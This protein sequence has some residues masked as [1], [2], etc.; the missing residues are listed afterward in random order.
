MHW[1]QSGQKNLYFVQDILHYPKLPS[2][3]HSGEKSSPFACLFF[4]FF[5]V[6]LRALAKKAVVFSR[7]RVAIR[8]GYGW[9]WGMT[10]TQAIRTRRRHVHV[11]AG[12]AWLLFP[13][14]WPQQLSL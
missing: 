6:R 10:V 3:S 13:Q 7:H 8:H 12:Q 11:Q 5:Y 14:F 1:V 2:L 9:S 4:F